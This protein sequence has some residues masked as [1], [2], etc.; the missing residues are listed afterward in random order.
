M[1]FYAY[2]VG[3]RTIVLGNDSEEDVLGV[4]T[5]QLKPRA[6]NKLLLHDALY[7]A[8]VRWSLV[9]FVS[10]MRIGFS[11]DFHTDGLDLFYNG[12]LFCYTT[13]KRDFII[14][15]LDNTYDNTSAAFISYFHS[16][17]EFVKWRAQLGHVG[18]DRMGRL[19][20]E[21]LLYRLTRIKFPRYE[22]CLA[23]KA[24]IKPFGKAMRAPS[25][26]DLKRSDICGPMNVRAR[27]GVIY[28]ITLID[29]YSRYGYVYLLC[30]AVKH[31]MCSNVL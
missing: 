3:S 11:F 1:K 21:A 24:T 8:G 14:L 15:D 2:P 27:H 29:D 12:N 25:P 23:G 9:S 4:G 19:P 7:A 18:Q 28:F 31:L 22:P 17:S 13:L 26:L 5:Y 30:I 16:N 10:L 20:K 6:G